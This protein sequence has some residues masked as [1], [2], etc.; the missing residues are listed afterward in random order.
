M[1]CLL[2]NRETCQ[3]HS[4]LYAN[5]SCGE[6]LSLKSP[7]KEHWVTLWM[8]ALLALFTGRKGV[9]LTYMISYYFDLQISQEVIIKESIYTDR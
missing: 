1:A 3:K 2:N 7:Y 9:K 8:I 4:E 5:K 6:N